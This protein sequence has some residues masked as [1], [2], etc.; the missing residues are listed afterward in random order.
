ML[1][2]M[3][4]SSSSTTWL[5]SLPGPAR[6]LMIAELVEQTQ[7]LHLIICQHQQEA[8]QLMEELIFFQPNLKGHIHLFR[9]WETLPYDQFSA[10]EEITAQRLA[11][12]AKLPLLTQGV[13]ITSLNNLMQRLPPK[14][15]IQQHS[16]LLRVGETLNLTQ[17]QQHLTQM[18]YRHVN[19]VMVPGEFATRGAIMDIFPSGSTL[20]FRIDLFDNEVDTI[21]TFSPESQ[22]SIDKISSIDLLPAREYPFGQTNIE[23]F[24]QAWSTHFPTSQPKHCLP[25][26]KVSEGNLFAGIDYYFPLFFAETA[27]LFD[28]LP[29]DSQIFCGS[30]LG[31]LADAFWKEVMTRYEQR[32]HDIARPIVAPDTLWLKPNLLFEKI[33]TFKQYRNKEI[34]QSTAISIPQRIEVN[35]RL[36][37]PLAPLIDFQRTTG[38]HILIVAESLG[39]KEAVKNIFQRCQLPLTDIDTWKDFLTKPTRFAVTLGYIGSSINFDDSSL[40]LL[41]ENDLLGHKVI[42][43]HKG[44]KTDTPQHNQTFIK[45]IAELDIG[46]PVVHL[47]HGIGRYRG[48]T[49]MTLGDQHNEFFTIEYQQGNKLYVPISA[50]H[51]ISRYSTSQSEHAPL[52]MLGTE[53]WA[54]TKKKALMKAYD[55]AA[56]LLGI[57]AQREAFHGQAFTLHT[58]DNDSFADGFPFE[59]TEDQQAAIDAVLADLESIKP[60]DRII[61][62]DVGFGKTEVAMR[63]S[64][65]TVHNHH[66]VAILVPTT[67]L[68][69]QHGQN[70]MDRFAQ[71]PVNIQVL[72]RFKTP[73]EQKE[74]L[75]GLTSGQVDIVI[76][77]HKLLQED[78]QFHRLGLLVIDEEHRFGVRQKEK[79]KKYKSKVN[80]LTMTATPIPRTL[81]MSMANLRDFSIIAT[82]PQRR[83]AIK[84]FVFEKKQALVMEAIERE[85]HR[86]GQVFFL[87][88]DVKSIE[89]C[90]QELREWLPHTSIRVAHGQMPERELENIMT[91]FYHQRFTILVCSTIIETGIDI[92]SANTIIIDRADKLG[93]AQ[94]HQLRGRVGRS[95]HQA[96]A[97]L[98]YPSK[99]ALTKDAQKRLEAIATLGEL[100]AGFALAT[101][102]L[103]IRGAGELLGEEQSGQMNEVGFSLYLD[104]ME[105][106]VRDLKSGKTPNDELP[107]EKNNE[108]DLGLPAL[109][110]DDYLPDV[111]YRLGFYKRI[112]DA[113][114]LEALESIELE[115]IDRFGLLPQ[116][117]KNLF[118]TME[119]KHAIKAMGIDKLKVNRDYI[120]IDFSSTTSVNPLTL[121]KLVQ[122]RPTTYKLI[123]QHQLQIRVASLEPETRVAVVHQQLNLLQ[124]K[125]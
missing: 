56:E 33:N 120:K 38:H 7:T 26:Q 118:A 101:H 66:Q 22:L 45:S 53:A 40:T 110:P 69:E 93:L 81:N 1:I 31:P 52:H 55:V 105:K 21:R 112:A 41:T 68:A 36:T 104:L 109:I 122:A 49:R 47:E 12:L 5:D 3:I 35:H 6:A 88:N 107:I 16:F 34:A 91:D 58:Q 50:L 14:N 67:L 23:H 121:I 75:A 10:P 97:Y 116:P 30:G 25:Y 42:Q 63:A 124:G 84:T 46:D 20:P 59:E 4:T 85:L 114:S 29:H 106:A 76:G 123:G 64:F 117:T 108:I 125:S 48:L 113:T 15:Y 32:R 77:T 11:L 90:A 83:L 19:E 8:D 13:V 86:G 60:M 51:L 9:D 57:Y 61:C 119:L 89:Y 65:V 94:L 100:G 111:H 96:Y 28:Y 39:R 24:Q 71:W 73:K 2:E 17:T 103:E 80:I 37:S 115:M 78:I 44:N 79:L 54:K 27:T 70:F 102:D 87:H 99:D 62:G 74:I 95:Y 98:L 43:R 18:G 82:P 72:S 92:P